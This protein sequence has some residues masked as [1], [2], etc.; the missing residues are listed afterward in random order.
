MGWNYL[1]PIIVLSCNICFG[2]MQVQMHWV[3][4]EL[5]KGRVSQDSMF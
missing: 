3:N 5:L 4:T 2:H 1:I